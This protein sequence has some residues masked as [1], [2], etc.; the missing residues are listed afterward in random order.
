MQLAW[1]S[2]LLTTEQYSVTLV[3]LEEVGRMLWGWKRGIE[4]KTLAQT[5][6]ET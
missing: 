3:D 4:S 1:E 5:A 6:R 2:Q